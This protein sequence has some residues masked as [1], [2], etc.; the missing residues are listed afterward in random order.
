MYVC[1]YACTYIR[2]I[3][4]INNM[5]LI[6]IMFKLAII[7]GFKRNSRRIFSQTR[8][9]LCHKRARP[10]CSD[11]SGCQTAR[12]RRRSHKG[13]FGALASYLL[14]GEIKNR[15]FSDHAIECVFA[16]S[17]VR[18]DA[19]HRAQYLTRAPRSSS[20]RLSIE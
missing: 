3:W 7:I 4:L 16:A 5:L 1:M 8:A 20:S 6:I 19:A 18:S 12:N 2:D 17:R 11:R 10:S 14:A 13:F 9:S 15:R